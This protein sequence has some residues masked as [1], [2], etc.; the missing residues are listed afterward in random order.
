M[1]KSVAELVNGEHWAEIYPEELE[2]VASLV[3]L[4]DINEGF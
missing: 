2:Y 1:Y 3:V 4:K